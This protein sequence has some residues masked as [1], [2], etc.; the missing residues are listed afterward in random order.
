MAVAVSS[1]WSKPLSKLSKDDFLSELL[2]PLELDVKMIRLV[3][4]NL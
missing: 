1:V 3:G 2:T 4:L